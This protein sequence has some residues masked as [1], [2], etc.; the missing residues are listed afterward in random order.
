MKMIIRK[1]TIQDLVEYTDCVIASWQSAYK[2]IVPDEYLN[3]MLADN[4]RQQLE[5]NKKALTEPGDCE[6]YC[7]IYERKMIGILVINKNHI[8]NFWAIYLIE[9]FWGKGYGKEILDFAINELKCAGHKKICLWVFEDNKR[10]RRFY[11]K[12]G[13]NYEGINKV[14]YKY[15]GV[16]LTELQYVLN[17]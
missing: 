12:N 13:F 14:V 8:E 6:Y 11:E 17:L 4:K 2:G 1:A 7:A 5:K 16:P 15:G 9:E 10:A 3:G